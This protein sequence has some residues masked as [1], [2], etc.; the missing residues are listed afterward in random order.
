MSTGWGES[1]FVVVSQAELIQI[2]EYL[3]LVESSIEID[4]VMHI[5][6]DED[7][8][9]LLRESGLKVEEINGE[10]TW[11][12][13]GISLELVKEF[14]VTHLNAHPAK[15]VNVDYVYHRLD[16]SGDV[17]ACE[18][19]WT[20]HKDSKYVEQEL[21]SDLNAMSNTSTLEGA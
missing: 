3:D 21:F 6:I 9:N 2:P 16:S 10:F 4:P 18:R 7:K 5:G 14:M 12:R 11:V 17:V 8:A 19:Y 20:F 15:D 13:E 1:R